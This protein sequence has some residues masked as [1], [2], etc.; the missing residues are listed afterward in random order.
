MEKV[1]IIVPVYNAQKSI[2]R[3]VGS[4][5]SQD[6]ENIEV[7][8]VDD[9]SK[10]DSGRIIDEL[11]EKDSR[12]RVIHKRNGGVSSTRNR[13]ISEATGTYLQFVDADDY[14]SVEATKLMVRSMEEDRSDIVVSDFYRVV[15]EAQSRK[16]SI[17]KSGLITRKEYAD[18]MM[19]SPADLYYGV[20]WN[21]L[22]RRSIVEKFRVSMDENISF[23]EDMIFNLEY[24]LHAEKVSVLTV[25]VYYYIMTPGSLVEQGMNIPGIIEMKTN[26]ISYYSKFYRDIMSPVDY[27]E[28]IPM[29]YGYLIAVSR[30]SLALNLFNHREKE[31]N[32]AEVPIKPSLLLNSYLEEA[33]VNRYLDTFTQKYSI[34]MREGKILYCLHL[35][36]EPLSISQIADITEYSPIQAGIAVGKLLTL[37]YIRRENDFEG[38]AF[39][40]YFSLI[41]ENLKQDLA[42]IEQDCSRIIYKGMSEE[43]IGIYN[44]LQQKIDRNII[45]NIKSNQ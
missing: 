29:I 10:D 32:P 44:S 37:K 38:D 12:I 42:Y 17:S 26:V 19:L 45:E 28:R 30:D 18:E 20:L 31:D 3:C 1:S 7:I 9:G 13:G 8:L 24:L 27:L 14:L 11:A 16:G 39:A 40:G 15:G 22:Y 36:R 6:Y 41:N 5:L 2:K 25:P 43:E 34:E 23:C 4:I 21:K 33:M 35:S